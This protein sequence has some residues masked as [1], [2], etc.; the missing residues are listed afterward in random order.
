MSDAVSH[1]TGD[2]PKPS[3]RRKARQFALQALYQWHMAGGNVA[4]IEAQFRTDNDMKKVDVSYFHDLLHGVTHSLADIQQA[5]EPYLDR[6]LKELDPVELNTLRIG[7]FELLKRID[8]P[9]KVVI[10]ESIELAKRFG[11]EESHRYVNGV[12]DKVAARARY[13][14]V[15]SHRLKP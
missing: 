2:K 15:N 13:Q 1:P 10:N 3:A 9:Y 12:L 8:V 4:A 7:A 11:A 5:I 14:E 6:D